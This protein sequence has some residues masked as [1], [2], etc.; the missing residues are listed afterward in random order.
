M[1]AGS[2]YYVYMYMYMLDCLV[3]TYVG[4]SVV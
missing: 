3:C 2:Y 4:K 1:W